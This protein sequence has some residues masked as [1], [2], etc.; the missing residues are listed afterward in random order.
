GFHCSFE[1]AQGYD[2][3]FR[4]RGLY[5]LS[6]SRVR[7]REL[8]VNL[9]GGRRLLMAGDGNVTAEKDVGPGEG[10]RHR[11]SGTWCSARFGTPERRLLGR[12]LPQ[13]ACYRSDARLAA[14]AVAAPAARGENRLRWKAAPGGPRSTK[15]RWAMP[16][17]QRRGKPTAEAPGR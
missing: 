12:R 2:L 14:G 7:Q 5:N 1:Q 11:A 6:Q 17:K 16:K 4:L 10:R 8:V 13:P 15:E 9:G 3:P